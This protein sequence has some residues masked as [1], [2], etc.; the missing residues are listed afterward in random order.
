M[1][2][3][4]WSVNQRSLYKRMAQCDDRPTVIFPAAEYQR[5]L[6]SLVTDEPVC[7]QFTK[8][9]YAATSQRK[10]NRDLLMASPTSKVVKPLC[11]RSRY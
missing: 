1:P 4:L 5:P 8:R 6:P 10:S 11:H 9:H 7:E 2:Y 3:F